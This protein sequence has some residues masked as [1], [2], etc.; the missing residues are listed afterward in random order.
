MVTLTS[1]ASEVFDAVAAEVDGVIKTLAFSR[2][3]KGEYDTETG[4]YAVTTLDY[5]GRGLAETENLD[6]RIKNDFPSYVFTGKETIW[7]VSELD[8]SPINNDKV[9]VDGK[10]LTIVGVRDILGTGELYRLLLI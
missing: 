6:Y 5:T 8:E 10:T 1:I 9:E 2:S 4:T 3:V 7:F